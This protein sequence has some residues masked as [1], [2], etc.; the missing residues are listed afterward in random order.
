VWSRTYSNSIIVGLG[1]CN[2]EKS[3]GCVGW[4]GGGVYCLEMRLSVADWL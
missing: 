4:G 3:F 2:D 1:M